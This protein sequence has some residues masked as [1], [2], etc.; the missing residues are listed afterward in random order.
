[1]LS[2]LPHKNHF[3][4]A[5]SKGS[6]SARVPRAGEGLWRSR[7]FVQNRKVTCGN[8]RSDK[9]RFGATPKPARE[10][11]VLPALGMT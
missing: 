5:V 7:T 8:D 3:W 9:V 2:C 10:T 11:R 4:C 6:G 1:M